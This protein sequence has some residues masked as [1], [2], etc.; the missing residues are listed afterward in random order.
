MT[1]VGIQPT[2]SAQGQT[3]KRIQHVL[4]RDLTDEQLR[5]ILLHSQWPQ[6]PFWRV[7]L[8]L[9]LAEIKETYISEFEKVRNAI[10]QI[11]LLED[12]DG[13][14]CRRMEDLR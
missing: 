9:G 8:Q 11:E 6:R 4:R 5:R 1:N 10:R 3:R 13:E 7:A 12:P 2:A 14:L